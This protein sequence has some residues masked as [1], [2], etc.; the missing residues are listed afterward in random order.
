MDN[1]EK[2]QKNNQMLPPRS[3]I[4]SIYIFKGS[5][6]SQDDNNIKEANI[7]NKSTPQKKRTEYWPV[8]LI[9]P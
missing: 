3:D 2:D 5:S 6:K 4:I 8:A 7:C 1:S 9:S